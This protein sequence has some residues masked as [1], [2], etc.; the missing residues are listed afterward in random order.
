[1]VC[2][3][4]CTHSFASYGQPTC[5]LLQPL[6]KG[7]QVVGGATDLCFVF[8]LFILKYLQMFCKYICFVFLF[9]F[10]KSMIGFV[11]DLIQTDLV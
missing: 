2:S 4:I 3:E 5:K 1:M 9:D 11:F 10:F 8:K 6:K 7:S